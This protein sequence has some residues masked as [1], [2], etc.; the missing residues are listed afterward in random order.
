MSFAQAQIEKLAREEEISMNDLEFAAG[1]IKMLN[2]M[3]SSSA[4][5]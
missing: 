2:E 1:F 4:Y 3:P 5:K